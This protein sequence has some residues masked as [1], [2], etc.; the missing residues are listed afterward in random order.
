MCE[1][2]AVCSIFKKKA[3]NVYTLYCKKVLWFMH[4]NWNLYFLQIEFI[5][6]EICLIH[7]L[8]KGC[9]IKL[10]FSHS[11]TGQ[12]NAALANQPCMAV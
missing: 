5:N 8:K 12:I 9:F 11:I 1:N 7:L 2:K 6:Q 4:Y 3:R 10:F